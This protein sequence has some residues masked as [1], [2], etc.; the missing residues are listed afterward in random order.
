MLLAEHLGQLRRTHRQR[1]SGVDSIKLADAG[2]TMATIATS[3][4]GSGDTLGTKFGLSIVGT[5]K[6][7]QSLMMNF[8]KSSCSARAFTCDT[9]TSNSHSLQ[10]INMADE[11]YDG[12]IGIDLGMRLI[13]SNFVGP[14]Y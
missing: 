1:Q 2:W 4:R 11:V 7:W 14:D 9:D 3:G 10:D 5:L 8:E 13:L 12:A 6:S